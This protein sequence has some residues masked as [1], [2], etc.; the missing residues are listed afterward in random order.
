MKNQI[1]NLEDIYVTNKGHLLLIYVN[2]A[3]EHFSLKE[4]KEIREALR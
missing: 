2:G 4:T 1:R 3:V